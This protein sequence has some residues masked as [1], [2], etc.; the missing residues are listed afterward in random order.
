M[1]CLIVLVSAILTLRHGRVESSLL[2]QRLET[3]RVRRA[4]MG[5]GM[6]VGHFPDI[7]SCHDSCQASNGCGHGSECLCSCCDVGQLENDGCF[8]YSCGPIGK[9]ITPYSEHKNVDG[10]VNPLDPTEEPR[11]CIG[12]RQMCGGLFGDTDRGAESPAAKALRLER[13][14]RAAAEEKE[15]L[16]KKVEDMERSAA[17]AADT[18]EMA[19]KA[20]QKLSSVEERADVAERDAELKGKEV[21]ELENKLGNSDSK[22]KAMERELESLQK[23]KVPD[24]EAQLK[25]LKREKKKLAEELAITK[26]NPNDVP[27]RQ[28]QSQQEPQGKKTERHA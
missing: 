26:L 27:D 5:A 28:T 16:Q 6:L 4:A 21:E 20:V 1:R 18:Q 12:S 7:E 19:K 14:A 2:G 13:Q 10:R 15:S 22:K 17:A 9:P 11:E 23:T 8:C 25:S 24:L 3:V